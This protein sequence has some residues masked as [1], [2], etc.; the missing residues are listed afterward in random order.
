MSIGTVT[1][2]LTQDPA[3]RGEEDALIARCKAGDKKAFGALV[4]RYAGPAMGTAQMML[5]C[6]MD[7][8]DVSQEAFVKA[9]RNIKRFDGRSRFY[10]WFSVILRNCCRDRLRKRRGKETAELT[11]GHVDDNP[12][13][14]PHGRVE[15]DERCGRIRQAILKLPPIHREVIIMSHFQDLS[16]KQMATELG[17]PI[18]TV[19]SRLHAARNAL[20]GLLEGEET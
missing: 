8:Q 11:E 20:R 7:A 9:W 10:T 15:T 13:F 17:I 2:A 16:Y 14:D 1:L 6:H 5:N 3:N 4:K 19:T 12:F 18:G